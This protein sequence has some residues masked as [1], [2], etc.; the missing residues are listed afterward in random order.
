MTQSGLARIFPD[1]RI[2][3][4]TVKTKGRRD[5]SLV[6]RA[7]RIRL[8]SR[9]IADDIYTTDELVVLESPSYGS[10]GAGTWD[11]AWAWGSVVERLVSLDVPVALAAP[12]TLK[13][14]A[15]GNGRADKALVRDAVERLFPQ[16]KGITFDEADASSAALAA[17]LKRGYAVPKPDGW[18]QALTKIQWPTNDESLEDE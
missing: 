2:Y 3:T 11:R 12:L 6:E 13:K 15:T 8:L 4:W 18:E 17:A 5:A 14:V 7:R 16:L 1:G 9:A 10:T